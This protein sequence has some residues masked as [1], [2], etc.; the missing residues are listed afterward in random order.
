MISRAIV[1]HLLL[2]SV[3]VA[4]KGPVILVAYYSET[5]HTELV[6]E[7]VAEGAKSVAGTTIL[8]KP[9]NEIEGGEVVGADAVILGSPVH[10]A[11]PA[12]E[13]L[14]F[15]R[16][17]PFEGAPM[18]NKIGAAFVT[19]GGISAGEETTQLAILRAMLIYGMI[20]VGGP[21]WRSAFGAS[22]VV[23]E[24][25]YTTG[26]AVDEHFLAKGRALGQRV[27]TIAVKLHERT[28]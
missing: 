23:A 11:N 21:D 16:G 24:G 12:A 26:S 28:P 8:L 18:Q 14:S 9:I 2:V 19:A 1:L 10:N 20:V 27:A 7:A 4:G 15:I 6:A 13:V 5:G 25:A 22:A 3:I 17:W